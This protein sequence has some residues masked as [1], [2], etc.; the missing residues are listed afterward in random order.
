[1]FNILLALDNQWPSKTLAHWHYYDN[2][3]T[4]IFLCRFFIV[5]FI[6]NN[7][8]LVFFFFSLSLSLSLSLCPLVYTSSDVL[9]RLFV[10]WLSCPTSLTH[11]LV[12]ESPLSPS[13]SFAVSMPPPLPSTFSLSWQPLRPSCLRQLMQ[14]QKSVTLLHVHACSYSFERNTVQLHLYNSV[15]ILCDWVC[16][17]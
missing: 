13:C 16:L 6:H 4:N 3:C 9:F 17:S 12:R 10:L 8:L 5:W 15:Y 7:V 2:L 11:W 14:V 1:M